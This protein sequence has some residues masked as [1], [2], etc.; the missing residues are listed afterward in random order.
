MNAVVKFFLFGIVSYIA[1]LALFYAVL[2]LF[3]LCY[4][5]W[6]FHPY[7]VISAVFLALVVYISFAKRCAFVRA[8]IVAQ[9]VQWGWF[10]VSPMSP[11]LLVSLVAPALLKV[12]LACEELTH[13]HYSEQ[14]HYDIKKR[15]CQ[16]PVCDDSVVLSRLS[17]FGRSLTQNYSAETSSEKERALYAKFPSLEYCAPVVIPGNL[18]G[19]THSI[20]MALREDE[21][22]WLVETGG[23]VPRPKFAAMH[24][25]ASAQA[26]AYVQHQDEPLDSLSVVADNSVTVDMGGRNSCCPKFLLS[27]DRHTIHHHLFV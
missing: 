9:W 6:L 10:T 8:M 16:Y 5:F 4:Y 13:L 20:S 17:G 2:L 24:L 26:S 15:P 27:L 12:H 18:P 25:S 1:V 21:V 19:V 3:V 23:T 14:C 22:A 11:P 7:W